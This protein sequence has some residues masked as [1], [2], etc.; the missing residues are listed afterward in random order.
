MLCNTDN[1]A[2]NTCCYLA[3]VVYRLWL[4]ETG[5]V[6]FEGATDDVL[7]A[8]GEILGGIWSSFC[9]FLRI[10]SIELDRMDFLKDLVEN[11][12]G[13]VIT[14]FSGITGSSALSGMS[15]KCNIWFKLEF[16]HLL[17]VLYLI[18]VPTTTPHWKCVI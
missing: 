9:D 2:T 7:N 18:S 15:G 13:G 3:L 8:C 11:S 5:Q 12:L 10:L 1:T 6:C 17:V 14:C 4:V 16:A